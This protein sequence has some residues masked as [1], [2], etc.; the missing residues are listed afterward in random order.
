MG[1][2]R[3]AEETG[4]DLPAGDAK[5]RTEADRGDAPDGAPAWRLAGLRT[6]TTSKG[7]VLP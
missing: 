5:A 1:R 6:A 4:S 3:G 2:R 7:Y